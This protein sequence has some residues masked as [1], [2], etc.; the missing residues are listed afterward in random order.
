MGGFEDTKK[1]SFGGRLFLK[2]TRFDAGIALFGGVVG[3]G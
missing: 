3:S 1:P 2:K